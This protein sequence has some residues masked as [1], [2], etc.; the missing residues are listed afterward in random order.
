VSPD[1]KT[2]PTRAPN[3]GNFTT[4]FTVFNSGTTALNLDISCVGRINV[5]CVSQSASFLSLASGA[6]STVNV[7]Y[8]VGSAG[9]G[10]LVVTAVQDGGPGDSGWVKVPVIAPDKAPVVSLSPYNSEYRS[11]SQ[12]VEACFDMIWGHT[13]P[14]YI[15]LG[16]SR[17]FGLVY[18]SASVHPMPTIALNLSNTANHTPSTYSIKVKRV[19][20]S[21][22]LT[23]L[24]G[25]QEVWFAARPTDTTRVVV[26]IDAQANGLA[27]GWYD[28]LVSATSNYGTDSIGVNT[29]ST[30]LLV[31]DKSTGPLGAG[32]DVAGLQRLY[33][34]TGSTSLMVSEG[35]GTV[36][37]YSPGR[38]PNGSTAS[39]TTSGS[40]W[41][42]TYLD[43]TYVEFG[44]SGLMTRAADR[45]GNAQ[46][47]WYTG[48]QLDSIG[49]PW[50]WK[51]RLSYAGGKLATVTDPAG[52]TT[53]YV[54]DASN[55]LT[56][57]TDP[58]LKFTGLAY[59]SNG[60]LRQVTGRDGLTTDYTYDALNKLEGTQLKQ[61][62]LYNGVSVRPTVQRA[63]PE[64]L[65]WQSALTGVSAATAKLA[66]RYDTAF[67]SVTNPLGGTT[68]LLLDRFGAPTKG[69]NLLGQTTTVARDSMSRPTET[70]EPS[71]HRVQITYS[72]F[73]VSSVH[74]MT[75]GR[76]VTY[77][78]N[79][80]NDVVTLGT[81][82]FGTWRFTYHNGSRG[83]NGALDSVVAGSFVLEEHFPDSRG[84]DTLVV[85]GDPTHQEHYY[86]SSGWGTLDMVIDPKG[87]VTRWHQDGA[88]RA[89]SMYAP[90]GGVWGTGYTALNQVATSKNSLG[91]TATFEYDALGMLKRIVDPKG[92][93]NRFARNALG[94]VVAVYDLADTLRGDTFGYD[95]GGL[96]RK[97]T[98]RRGDVI[99]MT[100]DPLGRI[101]T[102]S[103]STI[104]SDTYRYDPGAR[105]FV[106]SNAFAY[107][108]I[109]ADAAGRTTKD[110]QKLNG[111]TYELRTQFDA[112]YRETGRSLYIGDVLQTPGYLSRTF[113]ATGALSSTDAGGVSEVTRLGTLEEMPARRVI[114]PYAADSFWTAKVYNGNHVAVR[115]SFSV[116]AADSLNG[117]AITYE[118][119]GGGD[120]ITSQYLGQNF[121]GGYEKRYR[122][123]QLGRLRQ[124]CV[125]TVQGACNGEYG[126]V[127][128][129]T[130]IYTYDLAGNRTDPLANAVIGAG[131]RTSQ[132]KGYTL[133]YDLNG[134]IIAKVGNGKNWTY[135]WDGLNRLVAL[136]QGGVL[137][138]SMTYD[139]LGRRV[140]R[141]IA[142]GGGERYVY[143]EDHVLL[144]VAAGTNQILREYGWYPGTDRLLSVT[145]TGGWTG[146]AV[147]DPA[148]NAS[149]R[150]WMNEVGGA[151]LKEYYS[152]A[153]GAI[154]ADTGVRTRFRMAGREYDQESGLYFM[155]ARYYDA[156]LG[157]FLSEDPSGIAG[158]LNLYAYAEND[159][160]N[161]RDP[162]GLGPK[163]GCTAT[164]TME[165]IKVNCPPL[166]GPAGIGRMGNPP[167]R[168]IGGFGTVGKGGGPG[169]SGDEEAFSETLQ[170]ADKV[171]A[172]FGQ[173]SPAPGFV[174]CIGN[175][176]AAVVT[177]VGA[178]VAGAGELF[179]SVAADTR[180]RATQS[181]R[182]LRPSGRYN[183]GSVTDLKL[184]RE[185]RAYTSA[186]EFLTAAGAFVAGIGVGYTAGAAIYCSQDPSAF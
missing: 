63:A 10:R 93:V 107:D 172:I 7:T 185:A 150:G 38:V 122:Y 29:I 129:F 177:T 137:T 173:D 72:G 68:K 178:G 57:I 111:V 119:W 56:K 35:D 97:V 102:K 1:A 159:P 147:L 33:Q 19:S 126:L 79:G 155:R 106:A 5:T 30:R 55:R 164:V 44:S 64:R 154:S 169:G 53:Q 21:T 74:D 136:R 26:P 152:T 3:T 182:G 138:D 148:M 70:V 61:V 73:L 77:T 36:A 99:N 69:I 71:G 81:G 181:F 89:D 67:A 183:Y 59:T 104:T 45:F 180:S 14:A 128:L 117:G 91:Q 22:F 160:V 92:Q 120:R 90:D 167:P 156:D 127:N 110:F 41:R 174:D 135:N 130:D 11:V 114:N 24:N 108:S 17:A 101:L 58:D 47:Y 60:L 153:W 125:H 83:P 86:Y 9:T 18:N 87:N 52:R 48:S 6:T 50:G 143:D 103:G 144:D 171:L 131:N 163:N 186:S 115:D 179:K 141:T 162:S 94:A 123:D 113:T 2:E 27:T 20:N 40:G 157:R 96:L 75:T 62:T 109:V 76:Q 16:T 145:N 140:H 42:R 25:G 31:V 124:A 65:V 82:G 149:V 39:L 98:T 151:R 8:K 161:S 142:S 132:F 15:S 51:F 66:V 54:I 112:V 176:Y 168:G 139:A 175:S 78:Y 12:C 88:G 134:N 13:T 84:R 146:V 100:Y 85:H 133:S 28:V 116:A 118:N 158:G 32:V 43:G 23:L 95:E 105:W 34:Q 80:N 121:V 165:E 170:Q 37:F 46:T 166:G 4:P 184:F 49:D